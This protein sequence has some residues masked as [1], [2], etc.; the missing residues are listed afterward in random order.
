MATIDQGG[1]GYRSPQTVPQTVATPASAFDHSG[2]EALGRGLSALGGDVLAVQNAQREETNRAAE[3]SRRELEQ[4]VKEENRARSAAALVDYDLDAKMIGDK[5][6]GDLQSGAIARE[7]VQGKYQEAE[8]KLRAKTLSQIPADQQEFIAPRLAKASSR[9]Q[10]GLAQVAEKHR[11]S[12]ILGY[13]SSITDGMAKQAVEADVDL[14]RIHADYAAAMR[15]IMPDGGASPKDVEK[16]IQD[17]KDRTTVDY[18]VARENER[19]DDLPGLQDLKRQVQGTPKGAD[20]RDQFNTALSPDQEKQFQAWKKKNAPNDSGADYDLRGAFVAGLSRNA[21][22]DHLPD[23]FKKPNHPTFSNESQYAKYGNAGHWEGDTFV[24]TNQPGDS[25]LANIDPEKRNVLLHS[26]NGAINRLEAKQA[27]DA[28]RVTAEL[29]TDLQSTEKALLD[30]YPANAQQLISLQRRAKGTVLEEHYNRLAATNAYVGQFQNAPLAQA[31]AA[32]LD[33]DMKVRKEPT[34][35]GIAMVGSM[36]ALVDA[37]QKGLKEDPYAT[38]VKDGAPLAVLDWTNPEG[39]RS[40]FSSRVATVRGQ[41]KQNPQASLGILLPAEATQFKEFLDTQAPKDQVKLLGVMTNA[42]NDPVVTAHTMRQISKESPMLAQ[43]GIL[44][45]WGHPDAAM[46]LI[47]GQHLMLGKDGKHG[48]M[49]IPSDE[50][51]RTDWASRV[52]N[53]YTASRDA[54]DQEFEAAKMMYVS[55]ARAAGKTAQNDVDTTLWRKAIDM[56]TGGIGEFNSGNVV[57]PYGMD[58][59][60]FKQKAHEAMDKAFQSSEIAGASVAGIKEKVPENETYF[61]RIHRLE[62]RKRQVTGQQ[63]GLNTTDV[64]AGPG[65]EDTSTHGSLSRDFL[66][67]L[68]LESVGQG[69]YRVRQGPSNYIV[70]DEGYPL[71]LDLSR[72]TPAYRWDLRDRTARPVVRDEASGAASRGIDQVGVD[73]P[74]PIQPHTGTTIELSPDTAA[75][76]DKTQMKRDRKKKAD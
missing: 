19:L 25:S 48:A 38:A 63:Y 14:N 46:T 27:A 28:A 10:F 31:Q 35:K 9:V 40:S 8:A 44:V 66:K 3:H 20:L 26:I 13:A 59:S 43:A 74:V 17:F 18:V 7:D 29:A 53:A 21:P 54:E 39:L 1:F 42:I 51:F 69:V 5:V 36:R 57:L 70:N 4:T 22:G 56:S 45:S 6:A 15:I 30:G 47:D 24:P 65:T 11:K 49:T 64:G 58:Q 37:K 34:V 61:E 41:Q 33:L 71:L 67:D 50:K 12:E 72:S 55:L 62:Q 75:P 52:G 32:L 60:T 76:L 23:T 68:P 73:K 2:E 16:T